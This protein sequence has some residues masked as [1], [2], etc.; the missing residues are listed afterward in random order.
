MKKINILISY[1]I[2]FESRSKYSMKSSKVAM[3]MEGLKIT[4]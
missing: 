4:F 1:V 2:V 3:K